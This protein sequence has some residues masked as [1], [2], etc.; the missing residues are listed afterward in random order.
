VTVEKGQLL[1]PVG[2]IVSRVQVNRDPTSLAPQ[3]PAM[4]LDYAVGQG[5]TQAEQLFAIPA[6]FKAR[7]SRLRGQVLARDRVATYQQLMYR[8]G[9]QPGSIVAIGIPASDRHHPLRE[10]LAQL[11]LD[12]FRLPLVFQ[13]FRQSCGKSQTPIGGT[14]HNRSTVR[15]TLSLIELRNHRTRTDSRKQNALCYRRFVQ[16]KASLVVKNCVD[17]SFLP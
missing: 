10:Q 16:A 4:S 13:S 2:G 11:M 15:T 14:Q 3:T 12:L 1:R 9:T 8:I 7:Q 17:N 5:F 6:I